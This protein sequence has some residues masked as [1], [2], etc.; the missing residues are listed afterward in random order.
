MSG[1]DWQDIPQ[2][3]WEAY[4][5]R[6]EIVE[7][8]LDDSIDLPTKKKLRQQ[9]LADTGYSQRTMQNWLARY[10]KHGPAGLLFLRPQRIRSLRI[11]DAKLRQK[12][13]DLV[14]ESPERSVPRLRRLLA[15]DPDYAPLIRA[16]SDRS[17]YRYLQDNGLGHLQRMAMQEQSAPRSYH[18]FEAPHSLALVQGDARDGIW[19]QLPDG[20][21][22]KTYLFLWIDDFSRKILFGKYYLN[23]KLPCLEDSF[24]YMI[25][26]WGIPA[27]VY[28]DNGSVYISR[29]FRS[30]LAELRIRGLHHKPFQAHCKG[31]VEAVNK[32][33]KNEFQSE[34]A[35]AGMKT[36]EELNSAFWAWAEC[37][38]N[39]RIHSST[40]QAPDERF[41]QGLPKEHR[42]VEDLDTFQA[43]FLWKL[44][45]TVTKWG[46][47]SLYAN[48]Y[49]VR[50]RPPKSV[51]QLRFDPFDLSQIL[52]YDA[53]GRNRLEIAS[54]SKQTTTRAPSV[55]EETH[56][57][58]RQVSAQSVA[59]FSRLRERHLQS[60]KHNQDVS[61]QNLRLP[62]AP[63]KEDSR[64]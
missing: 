22:R 39:T 3:A 32:T 51:V 36:L 45:R 30:V 9:F 50:S 37:E 10:L 16:V 33:I 21:R 60:Q 40:G 20:V 38:Y 26:R 23:E 6:L 35:R 42:R 53:E 25:L 55:P 1:I 47:V 11:A 2:P 24:R 59:Y 48:N 8:I 54:A 64:G 13:L 34:A 41:Q 44:R 46:K 61:F 19:L 43:M 12:V 28:L 52:I 56:R 27:I 57:P 49:P 58:A 62:K 5:K 7:L 63:T 31:K 14:K 18:H 29:Q 17:V 15:S 4:D